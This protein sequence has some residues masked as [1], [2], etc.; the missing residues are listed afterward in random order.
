MSLSPKL[1]P[2]T[3]RKREI[4]EA[5][6]EPSTRYVRAGQPGQRW[7]SA[8]SERGAV[9]SE[10]T[11]APS[12]GQQHSSELPKCLTKGTF[13]STGLELTR[14]CRH[15]TAPGSQGTVPSLV[16]PVSPRLKEELRA[17]CA[18]PEAQVP[19]NQT[20]WGGTQAR[21]RPHPHPQ[22][23]PARAAPQPSGTQPRLFHRAAKGK[24][25]HTVTYSIANL[26]SICNSLKKY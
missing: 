11:A 14:P 21:A 12:A 3:R 4:H 24:E 9:R 7:R 10:S 8:R 23:R 22:R 16:T 17:A 26:R 2:A 20:G 1:A 15:S 18:G 25:I 5:H 6:P 13:T 19:R